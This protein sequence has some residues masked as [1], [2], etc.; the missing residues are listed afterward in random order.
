[1]VRTHLRGSFATGDVFA[2]RVVG[3]ELASTTDV[4]EPHV[5]EFF[6]RTLSLGNAVSKACQQM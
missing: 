4:N 1:M 5:T 2:V 3:N 6:R